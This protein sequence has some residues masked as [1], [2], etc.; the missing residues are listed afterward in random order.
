MVF[1]DRICRIF[2]HKK[3]RE[4]IKKI[5]MYEKER[6]F[7][8]HDLQ[9]FLDTARIAYVLNLEKKLN[10]SKDII[11]AVGLLHDIGR[12]MQYEGGIPHHEASANLCENILKDCAFNEE[13]IIEIKKAILNHRYKE[14]EIEDLSSIFYRA[15]K[16][17][18][19]CFSCSSIEKCNWEK[20]KKNLTIKY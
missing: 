16:L 2:N 1:E 12:W 3:F 10:I 5:Q 7:C 17:S 13:E 14:R 4:Y 6:K 19:N 18:R 15:D 20:D 8:K 11:Y 9:H